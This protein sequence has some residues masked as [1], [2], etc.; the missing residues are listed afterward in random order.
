MKAMEVSKSIEVT[1]EQ[2]PILL[3]ACAQKNGKAK[4]A[5]NVLSDQPISIRNAPQV[6]SKKQLDLIENE[7]KLNIESQS[8]GGKAKKNLRTIATKTRRPHL[9]KEAMDL[10]LTPQKVK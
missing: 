6:P 3:V 8:K 7:V 1:P 9:Q 2:N 5:F 10:H 4:F